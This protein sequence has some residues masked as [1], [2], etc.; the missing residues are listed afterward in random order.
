M[1]RF[2]REGGAP[3]DEIHAV[4]NEILTSA[5]FLGVHYWKR[6]GEAFTSK[7]EFERH[8]EEM[9]KCEADIWNKGKTEDAISRRVASA[10]HA[11]E[12]LARPEFH[13][14]EGFW[15][16]TIPKLARTD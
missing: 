14:L 4:L 13:A 7:E 16:R 1:A 11:I 6:Q 15:R 5:H 3:F 9:H 12:V 8:L 10:V 2:G